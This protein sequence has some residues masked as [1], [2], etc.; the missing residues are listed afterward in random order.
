MQEG[1]VVKDEEKAVVQSAFFFS[2]YN[3][4]TRYPHDVQLLNQVKGTRSRMI[5]LLGWRALL[6]ECEQAPQ[7]DLDKLCQAELQTVRKLWKLAQPKRT[8]EC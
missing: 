2:L 5:F 1:T 7:R 8:W 3:D 4:K 6:L